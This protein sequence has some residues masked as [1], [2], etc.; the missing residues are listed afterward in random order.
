MATV[1]TLRQWLPPGETYAS[2]DENTECP[3]RNNKV[4]R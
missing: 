2:Y 4:L 3:E 1:T